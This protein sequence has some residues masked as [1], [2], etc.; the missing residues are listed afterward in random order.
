MADGFPAHHCSRET[1]SEGA[2]QMFES[3]GVPV[4]PGTRARYVPG[5]SSKNHLARNAWWLLGTGLVLLG[6]LAG[7][8]LAHL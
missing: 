5:Q 2:V 6:A 4:P 3:E 1:E 7:W 8:L